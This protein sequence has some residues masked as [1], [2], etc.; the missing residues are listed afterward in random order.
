MITLEDYELESALIL[1]EDQF[2]KEMLYYGQSTLNESTGLI[3]ISEGVKETIM[4]YINRIIEA[5]QKAWDRFKELCERGKDKVYLKSI[6]KKLEDPK[7]DFTKDNYMTI[8]D[9][10]KLDNIKV[11]PF[12][13]ESMKVDLE[14]KE[15]FIK[16]YYSDFAADGTNLKENIEKACVTRST[17]QITAEILKEDFKFLTE[18]F[19]S[20]MSSIEKDLK[21][22]NTSAQNISRIVS[23]ITPAQTTSEATLIFESMYSILEDGEFHD[24]EGGPNKSGEDS[25]KANSTITSHVT[26]YVSATTDI[27]TAKMKIY[28]DIYNDKMKV[29]KHYIKPDKEEKKDESD[30]KPKS[31]VKQV[32]T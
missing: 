13:Y 6:A 28:K 5:I 14:S 29:I 31:N 11:I 4:K 2:Y 20:K 25:K 32:E 15:A 27:I 19:P 22:V 12:D 1:A 7:P 23:T 18:E 24:G 9:P 30:Q 8:K 16:K 26:N 21:T 10:F 17:K 3:S